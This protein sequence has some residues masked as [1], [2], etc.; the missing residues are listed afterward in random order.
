M[1]YFFR[2]ISIWILLL[3][4]I[5]RVTNWFVLFPVENSD[6][7]LYIHLVRPTP[8]TSIWNQICVAWIVIK[9][10][11][12]CSSKAMILIVAWHVRHIW[13]TE[14]VYWMSVDISEFIKLASATCNINFVIGMNSLAVH[15][16]PKITLILQL[17]CIRFSWR[18][19]LDFFEWSMR[20]LRAWDC[21]FKL[22]S[23]DELTVAFCRFMLVISGALAGWHTSGY[24]IRS[25][26][27]DVIFLS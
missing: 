20:Y 5:S 21:R 8:E 15:F 16:Q 14:I 6:C 2:S 12:N 9:I 17:W 26:E 27:K 13:G 22:L 11:H 24:K 4:Q 19:V 10:D 7:Y 3:S 18:S 25:H 1:C 23:L